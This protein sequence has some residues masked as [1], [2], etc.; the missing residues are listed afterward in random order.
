MTTIAESIEKFHKTIIVSLL[1]LI[2]L[3]LVACAFNDVIPIC[4]YVFG[5]DHIYHSVT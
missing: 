2:V 3:F 1:S 5:C 4:H